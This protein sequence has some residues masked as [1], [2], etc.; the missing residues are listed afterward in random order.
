MHEQRTLGTYFYLELTTGFQERQG[1]NIANRTTDFDQCH[2]SAGSPFN[3]PTLD[4]VSDV[5]NHLNGSAQVVTTALLADHLFVHPAG[6]E[7]ITLTHPGTDEALIV[8]QIQVCFRA[9]LGDKNLT[10]LERA[11][12]AGVHV[13]VRVQLENS[14]L[15]A[16]C[17]E[18]RS[19]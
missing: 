13:D 11:H 18:D 7:V 17:L 9:I 8:A 14:D 15:Q 12:G 2:I 16:A 6:G 5:R 4:L 1:F 3:N 10:V 19:Q